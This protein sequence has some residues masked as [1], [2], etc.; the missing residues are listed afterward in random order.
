MKHLVL[1][2]MLLALAAPAQAGI[3]SSFNVTSAVHWTSTGAGILEDSEVFTPFGGTM[4]S[5]LTP[6]SC[7]GSYSGTE[8]NSHCWFDLDTAA[9][10]SPYD[11]EYQRRT[12]STEPP[13]AGLI[14]RLQVNSDG[15]YTGYFNFT[16]ISYVDAGDATGIIRKGFFTGYIFRYQGAGLALDTA[17]D[18]ALAG[19]L[20]QRQAFTRKTFMT[21]WDRS[22]VDPVSGDEAL[23]EAEGWDGKLEMAAVPE[24][25]APALFGIGLAAIAGLRRRKR[26]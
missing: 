1:P 16:T 11:A 9:F 4:R 3:T 22:S 14:S 15:S 19:S 18:A 20:W 26:G 10:R 7:F 8:H 21:A 17:M 5:S 24:P 2:A 13:R 25:A 6:S 23:I 12:G